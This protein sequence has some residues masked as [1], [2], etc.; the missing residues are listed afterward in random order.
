MLAMNSYR[1][2]SMA[3]S[4]DEREINLTIVNGLIKA[5]LFKKENILDRKKNPFLANLNKLINFSPKM[6]LLKAIVA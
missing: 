1:K 6:D 3:D 4:K 2:H 5:R